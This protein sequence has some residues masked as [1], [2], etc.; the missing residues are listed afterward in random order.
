MLSNIYTFEEAPSCNV[1]E[2]V[3]ECPNDRLASVEFNPDWNLST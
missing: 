1:A 3:Q 2:V